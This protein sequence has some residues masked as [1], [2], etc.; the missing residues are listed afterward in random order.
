MRYTREDESSPRCREVAV[1]MGKVR[2]AQ[3][4]VARRLLRFFLADDLRHPCV[5]E[6][7]QCGW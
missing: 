2:L 7:N 5:I 4:H 3:L 6:K 1:A